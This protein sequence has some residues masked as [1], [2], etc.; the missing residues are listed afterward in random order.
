MIHL[1][2]KRLAVLTKKPK[3]IKRKMQSCKS[4][5]NTAT[6]DGKEIIYQDIL[7]ALL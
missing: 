1:N 3:I 4:P 5:A 6:N 7:C 2:P